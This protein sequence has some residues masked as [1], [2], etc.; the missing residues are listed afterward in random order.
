MSGRPV[1]DDAAQEFDGKRFARSLP[2]SPGVYRMLGDDDAVLYVGKASALDKRVMSYFS[3]RQHAPRIQMML[4]RVRRME[5]TLTRTEAE[6]LLLENQLIKSLRPRYNIL[7]RDDKS[8]PYVRMTEHAFPRVAFYRGSRQASGR[9]FGPYPGAGAVRETLNALHKLFRLRSCEDSIFAGRTRPCLQYQIARCTAPCVGLIS[10]EDYA[11]SVREASL[12]L[13]GRSDVLGEALQA[14]ME[15]AAEALDFE[16]AARLRDLIAHLRK[17]QAEQH[18]EGDLGDI[19][20]LACAIDGP[21]ACVVL[22]SYRN[23]VNLG[24]RSYFP[25]MQGEADPAEVLSAFLS[26]HYL[27][28]PPPRE[29]VL[30]REIE[31]RALIEAALGERIGRKLAIRTSVRSERARLLQIAQRTAVAALASE[32]DTAGAQQRR[33]DDLVRLL[34]L[35]A[36]PERIECFDISHTQ[37]EATVASCV[38]F[39]PQGA[40]RN[41]YRRFN[42]Q[43]ITP[44]DD[45]AAMQ[46]ALERRFRRAAEGRL[47]DLLLIDGSSGQLGMAT[48]VLTAAGLSGI[49]VVGVA[50]GESRRPGHETLVLPDGQRLRPGPDS[51]GLHLIQQVRDEAHR[52]A[53]TGHRGRRAKARMRS[54]LEDI[55]GI[56]ARRRAA[57]LRH[58]GGLAGVRAAG[59]EELSRVEGINAAL[60]R[61]IYAA[62]HET[63]S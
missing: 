8:Y 13:E 37:G 57:L 30:D 42:I 59:V 61:R 21:S 54:T 22:L 40:Q 60:A 2:S 50:K 4:S 12:F 29:I 38:V 19:D 62:L 56:G 31:D 6:A 43:D 15:R 47:P 44:G 46:Q 23:G 28:F 25:S 52:F 20:V 10:A 55:E 48:Q 18:V 11:E 34:A 41:E 39:G 32:I 27:Q 17:V 49:T 16:E 5:V 53:I 24:T 14:R 33:L 51:P 63:D 9:L 3:G 58:F 35:D 45:Y 7:M 36:P 26:Q 1:E